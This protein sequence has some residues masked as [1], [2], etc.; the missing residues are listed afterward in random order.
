MVLRDPYSICRM[1]EAAELQEGHLGA[2]K[3]RRVVAGLQE[4]EPDLPISGSI[5]ACMYRCIYIYTQTFIYE[6]IYI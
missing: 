5:H 4:A 1:P 3:A 2:Q 6:Y